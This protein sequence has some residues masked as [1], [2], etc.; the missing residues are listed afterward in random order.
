LDVTEKLLHKFV[1]DKFYEGNF[2][3]KK[4]GKSFMSFHAG[5]KTS[6]AEF[7][8]LT[9]YLDRLREKGMIIGI[10]AHTGILTEKNPLGNDYGKYAAKLHRDSWNLWY[11]WAD[12]VGFATRDITVIG[13]ESVNDKGKARYSSKARY[14]VF[15]GDGGVDA[16][17]R[18]GYELPARIP[19][20]AEEFFRH[21]GRDDSGATKDLQ[22]H[23]DSL[24][25]E[26]DEETADKAKAYIGSKPGKDKLKTAINRLLNVLEYESEK[27][28]VESI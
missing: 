8:Q 23:F 4:G 5:Y 16:K 12:I 14:L 24:I 26:V 22:E 1:C 28:N 18:A 2:E 27:K 11:D 19:L 21:I 17:C 9:D 20:D 13:T 10:I 15:E 25:G 3:A 7:K 6:A